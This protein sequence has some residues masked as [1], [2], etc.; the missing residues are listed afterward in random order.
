MTNVRRPRQTRAQWK[1]IID[2]YNDQ[3][4]E[5]SAFCK[6]HDLGYS[7]FYK[8]KRAF[9]RD[10]EP[11]PSVTPDFVELTPPSPVTTE[12]WDVELT[13][14]NGIQLRLRTR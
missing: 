8:W 14:G 7:T 3:Q 12:R 13:L 2:Q 5:A 1:R 11:L 6:T 4:Q 10:H 9:S